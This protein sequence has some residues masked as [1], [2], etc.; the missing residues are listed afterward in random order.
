MN[1]MRFKLVKKKLC[2]SL[3]LGM[4]ICSMTACASEQANADNQKD[5]KMVVLENQQEDINNV[6]GVQNIER[7]EDF[8][9]V[10]WLDDERIIGINEKDSIENV[11]IFD[12]KELTLKTLSNNKETNDN[13]KVTYFERIYCTEDQNYILYQKLID[14][15]YDKRII[16]VYDLKKSTETKL[17]DGVNAMNMVFDNKVI[18]AKG[19]KLYMYDFNGN[20]TEIKM[21]KEL[22]IEIKD[23]DITYEHYLDS[24]DVSDDER[25]IESFMKKLETKYKFE[26]ENNCIQVLDSKDDEIYI[27]TYLSYCS[28]KYFAYNLKT[29]KYREFDRFIKKE[30]EKT[31]D[32]FKTCEDEK[33]VALEQ[34]NGSDDY[35][36]WRLGSDGK[37]IE[38]IEKGQININRDF[39]ISQ[40]NSKVAYF[41]DVSD[42]KNKIVIYDLQSG[43][44]FEMFEEIGTV[45]FNKISNKVAVISFNVDDDMHLNFTTNIYT[46]N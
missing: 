45:L 5:N 28:N 3:I 16:Y 38:L 13:D 1:K 6:L 37:H 39:V 22:E 33:I 34:S 12:V 40:D 8:R 29:N 41:L 2:I 21:P 44:K 26:K 10:K 19:I 31:I 27:G 42:G 35:E 32:S 20:K 4:A 23:F 43:K 11:C 15:D 7:I 30:N 36:L 24:L 46:L 14:K 9:A 18:F 17:A 25:H